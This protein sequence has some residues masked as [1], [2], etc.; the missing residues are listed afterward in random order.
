MIMLVKKHISISICASRRSFLMRTNAFAISQLN[1]PM[2]CSPP[3]QEHQ[4][5]QQRQH[6]HIDIGDILRIGRNKAHRQ[7]RKQQ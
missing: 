3:D 1:I 7:Q 4:G 2:F 6:A 5:K